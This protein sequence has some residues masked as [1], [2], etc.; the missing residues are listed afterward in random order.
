[1]ATGS[2]CCHDF[3]LEQPHADP[4]TCNH[5]DAQDDEHCESDDLPALHDL[6]EKQPFCH[7]GLEAAN[8]ILALL[9][10]K[11]CWYLCGKNFSGL[12][13]VPNKWLDGR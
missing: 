12:V 13:A 1:M 3:A 9:E 7:H 11:Q 10:G 6:S 4:V 8:N 5:G 2:Q